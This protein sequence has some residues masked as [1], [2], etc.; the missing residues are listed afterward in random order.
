MR[1]LLR[2]AVFSWRGMRA[3]WREEPAFRLEA[4]LA[5]GLAALSFFLDVG[6]GARAA[7]IGAAL[8]VPLV[9]LLNTAVEAATDLA[10][11]E[12]HPLAA[13]AKDCGSAAVLLAAAVAAT[14][15]AAVLW[16]N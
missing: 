11:K 8:F 6:G 15:W 3:A 14:V 13:K 10:A 16:P 9:E 2:A 1:R 12:K 4:V 7:L 5:A